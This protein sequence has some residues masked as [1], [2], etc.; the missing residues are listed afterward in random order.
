[1]TDLEAINELRD[2]L[3]ECFNAG[4]A[5]P[6]IACLADDAVGMPP[7]EPAQV[8]KEV[9]GAYIRELMATHDVDESIHVLETEIAGDW[10]YDRGR[11]EATIV[12]KADGAKSHAGGDYLWILR[13]LPDGQWRLTR[14]IWNNDQPATG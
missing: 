4:D 11:W 12:N 6:V 3:V 7:D 5:D 13:K 2:R 9:Y 8:G 14:L 1:M 10:A